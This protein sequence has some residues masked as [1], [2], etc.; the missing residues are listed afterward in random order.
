[1]EA[2]NNEQPAVPYPRHGLDPRVPGG[3]HAA[4]VTDRHTR[5]RFDAA[6]LTPVGA[7]GGAEIRTPRER[8]GAS[9]AVFAR[10]LNVTK[11]LVSE[12]NGARRNRR[13]PR[14]GCSHWW[15]RTGWRRSPDHMDH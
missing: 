11:G 12:W 13:A 9:Q 14:S 2:D 5:R 10:Y 3:L 8:E 15:R 7:L 4:G 1:M 6:C